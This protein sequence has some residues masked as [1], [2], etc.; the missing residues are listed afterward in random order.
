MSHTN[1]RILDFGFWIIQFLGRE[2]WISEISDG[3]VAGQDLRQSL[4]PDQHPLI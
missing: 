4:P 3:W 1:A 2:F